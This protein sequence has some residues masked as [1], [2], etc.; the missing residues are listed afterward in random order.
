MSCL[1]GSEWGAEQKALKSV[2][3][4]LI[5]SVFDY[6]SI[7]FGSASVSIFK[8][9]QKIQI[10]TCDPNQGILRDFN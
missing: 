3:T 8:K 9:L 1:V 2:Y 5:R 4:G 10:N 6:D 7:A